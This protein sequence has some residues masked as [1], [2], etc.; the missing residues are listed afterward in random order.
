MQNFVCVQS[1]EINKQTKKEGWGRDRLEEGTK[2]SENK[3]KGGRE[4]RQLHFL[5]GEYI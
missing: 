5:M 4:R 2:K 3:K 1:F